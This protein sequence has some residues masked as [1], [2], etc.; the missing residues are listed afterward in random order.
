MNTWV[1]LL[2]HQ[3]GLAWMT[4][5]VCVILALVTAGYWGLRWR[6]P[7]LGLLKIGSRLAFLWSM[8]FIFGLAILFGY[9][10]LVVYLWYVAF[11][12]LKEFFSITPTRRA[13]RRVL[14]WAYLSAPIQFVFIL[15]GWQ[16]AFTIFVPIHVFLVLPMIMV[17][18]GEMAGFLKAWS[19][20]GWG[21]IT[22]VYSLGHLA[23][24]LVLPAADQPTVGGSGLFL[25]LVSLAQLSHALQ[26][27]F[28][29]LVDTP[30]LR[31]PVSTTRNG[32]SLV[33][34]V[35]VVTPIAWLVAPW[36][37]P[38][39]SSQAAILGAL[40]AVGAFIGYM[41]LSAIKGDL[42]LKDRGEMTPG[43][44]GVLNRIDA[45]V[46]TAPL[47]YYLVLQWHY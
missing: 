8:T 5:S 15:L 18:R 17:L 36:L 29:R 22:T 34:S 4:L 28:G 40:I 1:D 46:Y 6:R 9:Q 41:I 35:L 14:F 2:H 32:A 27:A 38:F 47:F 7:S 44:G 12:A 31:L 45:F 16:Q 39:T 13:D 19:L 30:S 33:G 43:R 25:F 24:L 23:Y 37:T 21:V 20:M 26:F 3:P 11:L 42:Q 10:I